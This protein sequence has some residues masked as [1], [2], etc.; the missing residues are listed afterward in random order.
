MVWTRMTLE[1]CNF[2]NQFIVNVWWLRSRQQTASKSYFFRW[3]NI[4]R[5][6]PLIFVDRKAKDLAAKSIQVRLSWHPAKNRIRGTCS[7]YGKSKVHTSN[8]LLKAK[9]RLIVS[10]TSE[11]TNKSLLATGSNN[12]Q[13]QVLNAFFCFVK[14]C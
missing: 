14:L 4:F 7:N 10:L 9:R 11:I 1:L 12:K 3:D 8:H 5:E 6:F 2:S 13:G